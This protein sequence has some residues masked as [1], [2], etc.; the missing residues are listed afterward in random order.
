MCGH[1]DPVVWDREHAGACGWQRARRCVRCRRTRFDG[2]ARRC[3][4][5]RRDRGTSQAGRRPDRQTILPEIPAS[6]K[7]PLTP[8]PLGRLLRINTYVTSHI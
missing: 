3:V 4:D 2:A 7:A 5:A 1:E 6:T 8:G